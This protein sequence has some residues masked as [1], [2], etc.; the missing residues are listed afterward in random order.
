MNDPVGAT[1]VV[2]HYEGRHN[3]CPLQVQYMKTTKPRTK[4]PVDPLRKKVEAALDKRMG[5]VRTRAIPDEE[6]QRLIHEL[7]KHQIELEARNEDLR[8]SQVDLEAVRTEYSNLFDFAPVGYFILDEKGIVY[9]TNLTGSA[10]LGVE[11][12]DLLKQSFE[13]FVVAEDRGLFMAHL[14]EAF[15]S[16]ER[17]TCELKLLRKYGP[18]FFARI[19]SI[20]LEEGLEGR[21]TCLMAVM[22]I[23]DRKR[24]EEELRKARDEL[25]DRTAE[26]EA[27]NKELEAFSYV[28][29]NDLKT[30]LRSVEGFTKAL[31]EDYKERLDDMGWDYLHRANAA[32]RRMS[33]LIDAMLTMARLT[34]SELLEKKVNLS[35]YA[36]IIAFELR[37][38][39]PE[40]KVNFSIADGLTARGDADLLRIVIE[41]LL[42]NAWKFTSKHT[43]A[44]IEFGVMSE[45]ISR[46]GLIGPISPLAESKRVFFVRD[47][48]AG[49]DMEYAD[50]LFLPFR[51]LHTE[52]EFPGIG[53]GLATVHM[54]IRRHG[55]RI[56]A[57]SAPEKGA[58]FY[59]TLE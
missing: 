19:E 48:G 30:P 41:N 49:F 2:A 52:S 40:R 11:R 12:V 29:A 54:I 23:T 36:E 25:E 24:A 31:M 15:E 42:S 56:W 14:K 34:R 26:I 59:F 6:T 8:R 45:G 28:V 33:Q 50:K 18:V 51:R 3:A 47:D 22:D 53:I 44:K 35:N 10:Y 43:S 9:K 5:G 32:S 57:E 38:K 17:K 58:T 7:Q 27:V 16:I 4:K 13:N 37:N 46:I 21:S 1:L 39:E 20:V 55:G